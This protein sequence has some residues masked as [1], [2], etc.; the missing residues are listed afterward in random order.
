MNMEKRASILVVDDENGIRQSLNMVLKDEFMVFL[1]GSGKEALEILNNNN[2][3]IALLDILLPD[4]SGIELIETIKKIDSNIEIIMITADKEIKSAVKAIKSGAYEYILKPFLIDDVLATINRVLEKN[5]LLKEVTYLREELERCQPLQKIIGENE[6][7]KEIFELMQTIAESSG[8]VLIQG[9]S[10]TGKELAAR[11]VHNLSSR[12]NN[13]FVVVN[14]AAIPANLMESVLFG[15][16]RGAFTGAAYTTTGRLEIADKGTVFLDDIDTLDI[17]MQS[18]LLRVIQ[19]KEF[20][21]VGSNKI[22]RINVRFIAASN[23]EL[24]DL[25][26]QGKFREDLF[27]RLNVFPIFIPPL[28][29]RKN[30]I[31]LLLDY[32]LEWNAAHN[33]KTT[34]CFAKEAINKLLEYDWPGNVRELQ[35]VVERSFTITKGNTIHLKDLYRF[36]DDRRDLLNQTLKQATHAFRQRYIDEVLEQVH[37]NRK[38]AAEILGIHRNTLLSNTFDDPISDSD[39]A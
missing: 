16:H 24:K 10:G 20:E 15:H 28:R 32:F 35:N 5:T 17:S 38:K 4:I 8:A 25:I 1:A 27:Y 29:K 13:P 6:Q 39:E 26:S 19:E 22:I 2:V 21:R 11:A 9:E 31:P 23:K 30:D 3:A 7:M 12:K 34:K 14:C 37:G 33:G 18:K 36:D